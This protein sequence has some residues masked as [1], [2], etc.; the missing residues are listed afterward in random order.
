[1]TK[2]NKLMQAIVTVSVYG[3]LF[4][5]G[6]IFAILHVSSLEPI[7]IGENVYQLQLLGIPLEQL[8]IIS[9]ND[10]TIYVTNEV[11]RFK[12]LLPFISGSLLV[13]VLL[14]INLL[15]KKYLNKDRL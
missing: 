7:P 8:T 6:A 15:V 5:F 2:T 4:C 9:S 10:D 14:P 3:L 12:Y 11:F 13:F 1:M